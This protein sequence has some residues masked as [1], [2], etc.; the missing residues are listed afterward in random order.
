MTVGERIKK[1]RIL[2]G[3]TQ[4]ELGQILGVTKASIQKYESGQIRNLKADTIRKLCELFDTL[5][6]YFVFDF[7][8][9]YSSTDIKEKLIKHYGPWI[10]DF[11]A[12]L[13]Q[14]NENGQQRLLEY[15]KDLKSI[16]GYRKSILND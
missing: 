6:I 11:L 3:L 1:F 2:K 5:P 7:V 15:C 12:I 13:N 10:M 9:D 16:E 14:L 4:E 8:E